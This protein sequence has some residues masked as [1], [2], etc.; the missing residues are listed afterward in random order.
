MDSSLLITL[1]WK[2]E[3]RLAL[4][5]STLGQCTSNCST[6]RLAESDGVGS[7]G[8]VVG[9]GEGV[10]DGV[11]VAVAVGDGVEVGTGGRGVGIAVEVGCTS[12]VGVV[13][14]P[15]LRSSMAATTVEI[16]R[17]TTMIARIIA[18]TLKVGCRNKKRALLLTE[19][20]QLAYGGS[21]L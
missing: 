10:G 7:G 12:D 11:G 20:D 15:L 5:A 3:S 17:R 19:S 14:S 21:T 2:I 18:T 8:K 16:T 13:S 9:V 4:K 1:S 6:Q